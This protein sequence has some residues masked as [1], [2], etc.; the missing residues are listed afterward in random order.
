MTITEG[1]IQFRTQGIRCAL[2]VLLLGAM[3]GCPSKPAVVY[4]NSPAPAAPA[5]VAPVLV[6]AA[7]PVVTAGLIYYPDYEVYYDP[8]VRIYWYMDGG[9][10]VNGPRPGSVSVDVLLHAPTAQMSF[11]D[12][13]E[14]H[15]SQVVKQYPRGGPAGPADRRGR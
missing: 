7:P 1:L 4:V 11:R 2:A 14:N 8:G 3:T 13:P 5:V 6:E 9:R 12:S 15:H 10:W